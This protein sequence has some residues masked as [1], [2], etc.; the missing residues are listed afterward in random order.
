MIEFSSIMNR[1]TQS[2]VKLGDVRLLAKEIKKNHTLAIELWK[3]GNF[4]ARLLAILI[5]DKKAMLKEDWN[6]WIENMYEHSGL[7]RLQLMDWLMANQLIKDKSL[8]EQI[9]QWRES[10]LSLK[11]RTFWYYEGRLRWMGQKPPS[12]N[13]KLLSIIEKEIMNEAPDVQWAMNFVAAQIGIFD[14]PLRQRCIQLGENTAL[15][16]D[17]K[18]S[19][20]CTPNYLPIYIAMQVEKLKL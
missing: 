9:L 13:E 16:K 11:R 14:K 10:E 17:E 3:S 5:L 2:N 15:Y 6:E 8:T 19:K 20:N 7:E 1:L 4:Y 18:Y 12:N